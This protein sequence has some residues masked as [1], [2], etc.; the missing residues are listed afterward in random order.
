[1]LRASRFRLGRA[2]DVFVFVCHMFMHFHAYIPSNFYICLFYLV[3]AFLIFSHSFS[4]SISLFCISCFMAPKHKSTLSQNPLRSGASS[5]FDPTPSFVWLC[6]EKARKDF[7]ENF[8]KRGIHLERQV[9]LS[10]FS[11]TDLPTII[12]SRD[13]ELLCGVLVICPSVIIQEFYSNMHGFDSLVPQFSTRV[14]GTCIVVTL[15][16]VSEVLP[17]PRVVHL[18]YPGCDR[19]R[20]VSKDELMSLFCEIPSVWGDR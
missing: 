13:W 20:T 4:P 3:G 10:D 17:V 19:L 2:H 1:M 5:S 16:I 12:H 15:D 6:D 11:N 9:I 7:S 18:D 8:S 14:R